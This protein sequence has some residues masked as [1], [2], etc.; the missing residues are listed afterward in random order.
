MNLQLGPPQEL[1]S[2]HTLQLPNTSMGSGQGCNEGCWAA[3]PKTGP[4]GATPAKCQRK[5]LEGTQPV[6]YE[7]LALG[8]PYYSLTL[9]EALCIWVLKAICMHFKRHLAQLTPSAKANVPVFFC[10]THAHD[11]FHLLY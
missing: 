10:I 3:A 9:L 6:P 5:P 1:L 2:D 8:F 4:F 11:A 7:A